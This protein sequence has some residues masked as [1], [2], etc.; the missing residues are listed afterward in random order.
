MALLKIKDCPADVNDLQPS[1]CPNGVYWANSDIAIFSQVQINVT[2]LTGSPPTIIFDPTAPAEVDYTGV[3]NYVVIRVTNVTT[4]GIGSAG[5]TQLDVNSIFARIVHPSTLSGLTHPASWRNT[6]QDLSNYLVLQ[7]ATLVNGYDRNWNLDTADDGSPNYGFY[8]EAYFVLIIDNTQLNAMKNWT[9]SGS[10][11]CL[12]AEVDNATDSI[13]NMPNLI[14]QN[15]RLAQRN[16]SVINIPQPPPPPPPGPAPDPGA[17]GSKWSDP[18]D[19]R[20]FRRQGPFPELPFFFDPEAKSRFAFLAGAKADREKEFILNIKNDSPKN[21]FVAV[22]GLDDGGKYFPNLAGYKRAP[23]ILLFIQFIIQKLIGF[24]FGMHPR[25]FAMKEMVNDLAVTEI[26]GGICFAI[27]K[28]R[29][30]LLTSNS[31]ELHMVKEPGSLCPITVYAAL[32]NDPKNS[33]QMDVIHLD[34]K[35][36]IR[37]GLSAIFKMKK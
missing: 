15:R 14:V 22:V 9:T 36:A 7:P 24:L 16:L 5:V 25:K 26:K 10:H 33:I 21:S 28:K 19:P 31:A 34:S 29:F 30:V 17:S 6:V 1:M 8:K 27:G 2:N 37:G 13:V 4:G 18:F 11:P 20:F 32:V 23:G 35:R 3:N 12:I